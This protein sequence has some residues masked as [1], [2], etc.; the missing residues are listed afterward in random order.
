MSVS[1]AIEA[2]MGLSPTFISPIIIMRER[3]CKG[4]KEKYTSYNEF[5]CWN[6]FWEKG[7]GS[8]RRYLKWAPD[9]ATVHLDS[10]YDDT[11]F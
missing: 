5:W 10:D 2:E 3:T 1:R 11:G 8:E 7:P 4:C 9:T 6:C